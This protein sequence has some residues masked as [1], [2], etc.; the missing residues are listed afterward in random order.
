MI[1]GNLA[2][3]DEACA[4]SALKAAEKAWDGGQGLW[5]QMSLGDRIQAISRVVDDL[6]LKREA[7]VDILMWEIAKTSKDAAAE[8]DR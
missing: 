6:K 5:P 3:M 2:Q 8:F 4:L 1:I 7:I